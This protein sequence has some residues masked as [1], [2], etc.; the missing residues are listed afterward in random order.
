MQKDDAQQWVQQVIDA[1]RNKSRE[2]KEKL[3]NDISS[4][5]QSSRCIWLCIAC[6]YGKGARNNKNVKITLYIS[7]Q[8]ILD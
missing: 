6:V 1:G 8:L 5:R 3:W 2:R 7:P 4:V